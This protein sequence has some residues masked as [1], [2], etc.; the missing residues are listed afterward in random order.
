MQCTMLG[1]IGFLCTI[2][3]F[4]TP[5]S[6]YFARLAWNDRYGGSAPTFPW[7]YFNPRDP[8]SVT[9]KEGDHKRKFPCPQGQ[10]SRF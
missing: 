3:R 8:P 2:L 10:G 7:A 5:K 6:A 1:K 4:F 9:A